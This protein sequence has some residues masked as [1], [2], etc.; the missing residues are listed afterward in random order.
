MY[1]ATSHSHP[2]TLLS[3]KQTATVPFTGTREW[4]ASLGLP[5]EAPWA[6]WKS[7]G[8]VAGHAVRYCAPEEAPLTFATVLR[9]GHMVP[10]GRPAAA[11]ELLRKW[12]AREI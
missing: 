8:Q 1:G 11:L 10:S 5:V 4:T 9:A 2:S 7:G 12:L 3:N 6:A